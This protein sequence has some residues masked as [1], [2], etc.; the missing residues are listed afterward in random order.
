MKIILLGYIVRGPLGGLVWHHFQYALGLKLLGHDVL[1]LEFS[2]DYPS[3]YNPISYELT[4][5]PT[6]GL[7]FIDSIFSNHDLKHQWAYFDGYSNRWFGKSKMEVENFSSKADIV[8]N[9]SGINQW[10]ELLQNIPVKAFIDTDPLFTQIR[11]LKDPERNAIAREHDIF[12]SFGE[13]IGNTDCLIPSSQYPW[14]TTRQPVIPRLWDHQKKPTSNGNW[15]TIMQWESYKNAEWEGREFGMKS[16][17]FKEYLKLPKIQNESFELALGGETAPRNKLERMGWRIANPLQVT[18]TP[19]SYQKYIADSKGEWS[20]AKEGYVASNSGWFSERSA[21]Y[22]MSS[23]PVILQDTGFSKFIE[24]G[25][26]LFSFK[27]PEELKTILEQIQL[28][29]NKQ[30]KKARLIAIEFFHFEKVLGN[31]LDTF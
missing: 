17:S 30:C 9:I 22:L 21:A 25:S 20:V 15:T 31:L 23:K 6:Y 16:V 27:S 7:K 28:D 2:D 3:C 18:L 11:L 8:L 19:E 1:F 14:K 4:T 5:D 29:Y 10:H 24:T 12:F 26:G 13:N